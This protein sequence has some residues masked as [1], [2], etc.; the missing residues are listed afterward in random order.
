MEDDKLRPVA[1]EDLLLQPLVKLDV[2]DQS[3]EDELP[4]GGDSVSTF[5][6]RYREPFTGLLFL[7]KIDKIVSHYGHSFDLK[8]PTQRE[9]IE[10]GELHKP[11]L[12]TIASEVAW[13]TITV[14]TYLHAVDGTPLPEP[15][16]PRDSGLRER[17]NW[18]L[19]NLRNQVIQTLFID[20]LEMDAQVD[21]TLEEFNRLG[22]A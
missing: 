8:T 5:D 21:K 6:R 1:E 10:G 13:A 18:V 11:Y 12:N 3:Q 17:F 7:G 2:P 4:P 19:D 20:C 15:L 16:G 9:K 14:A 22:E